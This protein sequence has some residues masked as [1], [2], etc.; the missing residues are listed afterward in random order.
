MSVWR[1][2][3]IKK[4]AKNVS[5]ATHARYV[6]ISLI[7]GVTIYILINIF[8]LPKTLPLPS[9]TAINW[10][11]LHK[12]SM[13]LDYIIFGL[14]IAIIPTSIVVGWTILIWRKNH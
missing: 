6:L 2:K 7:A 4:A 9:T 14:F 5:M 13:T 8:F 1:H 12:H 11:V 10:L 3:I